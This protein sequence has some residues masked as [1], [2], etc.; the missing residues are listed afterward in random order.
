[1]IIGV[2]S[3]SLAG[4]GM[5]CCR[6][7]SATKIISSAKA[8]KY[9]TDGEL[10]IQPPR[11]SWDLLDAFRA[12]AAQAGV[13]S[14]ADFNTGDNEGCCAFHVNQKRG[15]RWSAASAFLKP[16]L[17]RG[18]IRL[19]TGCLVES[20]MF[21]GRRALG[22]R[23][24]QSGET[25]SARCRGGENEAIGSPSPTAIAQPAPAV[26]PHTTRPTVPPNT[27]PIITAMVTDAVIAAFA[28]ARRWQHQCDCNS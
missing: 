24:R 14:I 2:S 11:V 9:G 19:E 8:D 1:M 15:R 17:K 3:G 5:T 10:L 25:R 28:E 18:N 16:A 4:A 27:M 6:I 23:W 20:V 12:A 22:V 26:T 13:K 21:D 7:S